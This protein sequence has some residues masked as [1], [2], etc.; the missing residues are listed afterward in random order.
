MTALALVNGAKT[1]A[2]RGAA[3]FVALVIICAAISAPVVIRHRRR[4]LR[5]YRREPYA[6]PRYHLKM[7]KGTL[8]AIRRSDPGFD[9][10]AFLRRAQ[11]IFWLVQAAF[12]RGDP[13]AGRAYLAPGLFQ[14]WQAR[15]ARADGAARKAWGPVKALVHDDHLGVE[16]RLNH[17]GRA[18]PGRPWV[19]ENLRLLD[20]GQTRAYLSGGHTLGVGFRMAYTT[21]IPGARTARRARPRVHETTELW[22]FSRHA[23]VR[24]I[25]TGG[26]AGGQCP[27][28]GRR[29]QLDG[30][31]H[32]GHCGAEITAGACDW[33]VTRFRDYPATR[34]DIGNGAST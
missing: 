31:G 34:T 30:A 28:C 23:C 20:V 14:E 21:R 17:V 19:R 27:N 5:R 1:T 16:V 25:G 33:T 24:T 9:P 10:E 12:E 7:T 15:A 2:P 13:Q 3:A 11:A 29:L 4:V 8:A 18:A 26:V 32:C 6:G 22:L